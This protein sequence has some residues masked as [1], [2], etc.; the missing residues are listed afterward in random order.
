MTMKP[1]LQLLK[2]V[3]LHKWYVLV[4]GC[5][6]RVPLW[7]LI[8]H[9]LSKFS[10]SE[11]ATYARN[12]YGDKRNSPG[13][14]RAWL[15]HQKHNDHHWEHWVGPVTGHPYSMPMPAVRE[16]VADWFAASKAYNGYWPNPTNFVW[17]N[18]HQ[19]RMHLHPDTEMRIGLVLAEAAQWRWK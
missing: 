3:L 18:K 6:L 8:A 1:Y 11:F 14:N 2:T 5:R 7:R 15:H 17:Y 9:D 19:E 12:F 16:M 4:A 13:F 10:S